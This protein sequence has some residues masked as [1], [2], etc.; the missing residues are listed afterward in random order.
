MFHCIRRM[1]SYIHRRT[2]KPGIWKSVSGHEKGIHDSKGKGKVMEL[3]DKRKYG[4]QKL[5]KGDSDGNRE[6]TILAYW[7]MKINLSRL[8]CYAQQ[9]IQNWQNEKSYESH[10]LHV[11]P[12]SCHSKHDATT[13]HTSAGRNEQTKNSVEKKAQQIPH[14]D[15][16]PIFPHPLSYT[17]K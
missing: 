5:Y 10:L 17:V 15:T 6:I 7:M 4:K 16:C 2:R 9:H 1:A 8:N 12:G 3:D 13:R 14:C 11:I